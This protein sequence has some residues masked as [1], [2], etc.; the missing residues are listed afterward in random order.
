[1]NT[2]TSLQITQYKTFFSIWLSGWDIDWNVI[3][4][5]TA[6]IPKNKFFQKIKGSAQ[7]CVKNIFTTWPP[8]NCA[9]LVYTF[10]VCTSRD[11]M[12]IRKKHVL[13]HFLTSDVIVKSNYSPGFSI[14]LI[15]LM[16]LF[17]VRRLLFRFHDHVWFIGWLTKVLKMMMRLL[18]IYVMVWYTDGPWAVVGAHGVQCCVRIW[19]PAC[20]QQSIFFCFGLVGVVFVYVVFKEFGSCGFSILFMYN[21][22]KLVYVMFMF[23]NGI[24]WQLIGQNEK[25]IIFTD[26]PT[27]RWKAPP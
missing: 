24:L 25:H 12:A 15:G 13:G 2:N 18:R 22:S 19:T 5:K 20:S 4:V 16:K 17:A 8:C 10:Q 14:W 23:S 3:F 27:H 26:P 1:M 11:S 7:G 21:I 6:K 9:H